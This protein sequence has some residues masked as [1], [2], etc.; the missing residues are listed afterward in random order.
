MD[1]DKKDVF[2]WSNAEE[3]K[4]YIGKEGYFADVCCS[5]KS[6]WQKAKLVGV[7][8]DDSISEV[9]VSSVLIEDCDDETLVFGLF[10]P[11]DKVKRPEKK[12]RPFKTIEE[13][14]NALGLGFGF[15]LVYRRKDEP[16]M[17][18][19]LAFTGYK[20]YRPLG[21]LYSISLGGTFY[22]VIHLLNDYEWQD[23]DGNWQPFGVKE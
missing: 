3:A 5:D 19:V 6:Y 20:R 9:F 17:E 8:C 21:S 18:F 2:S 16:D 13:F 23:K 14:K 10:I 4:Q 12:W 11:A 7:R 22:L 15:T 1:F